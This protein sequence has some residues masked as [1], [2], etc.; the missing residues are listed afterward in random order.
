MHNNIAVELIKT[1]S[2]EDVKR[3]GEYI[4]STIFNKRK[5][6]IKLFSEIIKCKPEFTSQVLKREKLFKKLYPDSKFNEQTIRTRMTELAALIRGYL[7]F[8]DFQK[9]SF[10][11]K[12]SLAKELMS[13]NKYSLSEKIFMETLDILETEKYENANYF[14]NKYYLLTEL[15]NVFSSEGNFKDLHDTEIKRGES[16]IYFFLTDFLNSSR[17]VLTNNIQ[18]KV[19]KDSTVSNEFLNCFS[20]GKFLTHLKKTG[21]EHSTLITIY[22]LAY[23]TRKENDNEDHYFKLKE[24]VFKEF[25]KFSKK[26]FS[27]SGIF[28]QELYFR[29]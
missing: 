9:N 3:F 27:I 24:I 5:E 13:R 10:Q 18:N 29:Y 4:S 2:D 16:L 6:L 11:Q 14:G 20:P 1:F 8:A 19:I 12:M 25:N 7:A 23:L 21:N 28:F 26:S 17:D 15:C 22:Y